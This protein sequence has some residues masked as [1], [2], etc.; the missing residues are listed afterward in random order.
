MM[1]RERFAIANIYVPIKRHATLK[2]E[3]VKKDKEAAAKSA[4]RSSGRHRKAG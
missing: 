1:R 3:T 2:P 4:A